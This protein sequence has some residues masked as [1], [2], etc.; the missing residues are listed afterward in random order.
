MKKKRIL[1]MSEKRTEDILR[2]ALADSGYRIFAR[3]P[4]TKVLVRE[5]GESLSKADR[6]FM[7]SSELDFV[8]ANADSIPEFAVEFDGPH[9]QSNPKQ[10][11]RD[12]RKNRL[13]NMAKLPLWRITETELEDFDRYTILEFIVMRFLVWRDES[14]DIKR[15]IAEYCAALDTTQQKALTN[16]WI[17]DPIIDPTV[18]FDIAHPFPQTEAVA[19]RLLKKYGVVSLFVEPILRGAPKRQFRL[20]CDVFA[21][22][23]ERFESHDLVVRCDYVICRS[24][25]P[26]SGIMSILSED[27]RK[28]SDV[29][30]KGFL[31]FRVRASLPIVND[32][33]ASEAPFEYFMRNR[34]IPISFPSLP[35]VTPHDIGET[36]SEY[37]GLREVE[38]WF[39]R[40]QPE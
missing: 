5:K 19:K 31:D 18:H 2:R 24:K 34:K 17:A 6:Q 37:L 32:Y 40:N 23:H 12:V 16:S 30:K 9:H 20:F 28:S 39:I 14:D 13:C 10:T 22:S 33:D 36:M 3:L 26:F 15:Q 35:G 21:W 25:R 27:D 1:N 29:L 4:L 8:I 38:K 7:E 11:E